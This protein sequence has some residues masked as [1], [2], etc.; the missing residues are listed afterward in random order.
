MENKIR[1]E[2]VMNYENLVNRI[3]QNDNSAIMEFYNKFYKDVYYVCYKITENEKDAEDV[4]QETL[5]KAIDKIDT[6][7]NPEG[8]SAWLKTIANNLSINYLKKNRKFDIVDNSEDMGEEVFEENRVSKKTPEDIVADKEVTDIL[9]NMINKLP[10]EQRITIFM[11]YYEELSVKEIAEIM[12]CSEA[13]VRSRINYARKALRKQVD[14]LENKGIKLRCIAILPFLFAVY[15]FEMT[16]VCAAVTTPSAGALGAGIKGGAESIVKAGKI[17]GEAAK[18]SL[19]AKIA[20]G[21]VAA[22]VLV[23]GTIG[24]VSLATSGNDNT[25]NVIQN[26]GLMT[27]EQT[28]QEN[29]NGEEVVVENEEDAQASYEEVSLDKFGE[30][31]FDYSVFISDTYELGYINYVDVDFRGEITKEGTL[32]FTGGTVYPSRVYSMYGVSTNVSTSVRAFDRDY[33]VGLEDYSEYDATYFLD[34]VPENMEAKFYKNGSSM[35]LVLY[36]ENV[37]WRIED[38]YEDAE[39]EVACQERVKQTIA[40]INGEYLED[41]Q[42]MEEYFQYIFKNTKLNS[43]EF[44]FGDYVDDYHI[45]E[46]YFTYD[47]GYK[48]TTIYELPLYVGERRS[49]SFR[50]HPRDVYVNSRISLI[51]ENAVKMYEIV[52]SENEKIRLYEDSEGKI[53]YLG[54]IKDNKEYLQTVHCIDVTVD[55]VVNL[56]VNTIV[57]EEE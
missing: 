1:K 5:I 13:T 9:T 14:E 8:L 26:S 57:L 33:V 3:K 49:V 45:P 38:S 16:S 4:A 53:F 11:F 44:H 29:E 34:A 54:L 2:T 22:I 24:V 15:S 6:L 42:N 43:F 52:F 10:R 40:C 51:E 56:L 46:C 55:E 31:E 36:G 25:D 28:G 48:I 7:K 41:E 27:E 19:K 32:N 35:F 47:N 39:E 20:I 37:A 12:D 21:A 17:A 50:W 23:G 30:Y 18:V